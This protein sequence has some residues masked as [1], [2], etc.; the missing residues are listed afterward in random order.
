MVYPVVSYARK[1]KFKLGGEHSIQGQ[2]SEH[3]YFVRAREDWQWETA[4]QDGED[5]DASGGTMDRP[6]IQ[7]LLTDIR[8]EILDIR[9]IVV[10]HPD[11]FSRDVSQCL[12]V[13]DELKEHGVK[14]H[15]V[16]L[17]NIDTWTP[18]G[19]FFLQNMTAMA[20]YER[21]KIAQHSRRG[22]KQKIRKGEWFGQAP[23][24][25][26]VVSET[27]EGTDKRWNTHLEPVED[28]QQIRGMI[29]NLYESG[30]TT[31]EIKEAL[32]GEGIK[33]RQGKSKW[34]TTTIRS[35]LNQNEEKILKF[36]E[37]EE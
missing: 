19:R 31:G 28:E 37:E 27:A 3:Q 17:P 11:R 5:A 34:S 4:Y 14:V 30:H 12:R 21:R 23:Y 2:I 35:I 13:V 6:G 16:A 8:E 36:T 25:W 20:E 33:T 9:G 22:I 18:E 10:S 7:Q 29:Y 15:F 32:E 24:G 1:S 26:R